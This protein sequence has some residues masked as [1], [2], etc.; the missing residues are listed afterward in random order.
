MNICDFC[1]PKQETLMSEKYKIYL[2]EDTKTRLAND[3]ELFE[4]TRSDGTVNLN[5]FLKELIVNY[6]DQYRNDNDE[7]LANML[8]ELS[9]PIRLL[10][11]IL[12]TAALQRAGVPCS[13]SRSAALQKK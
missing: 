8:N 12:I 10:R 4:F 5:G 7:L 3:A 13:R 6:F 2:S 11:P 1:N 9:W